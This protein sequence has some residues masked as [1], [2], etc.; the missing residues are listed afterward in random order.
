MATLFRSLVSAT[1]AVELAAAHEAD[2]RTHVLAAHPLSPADLVLHAHRC[3]P[4]SGEDLGYYTA[5]QARRMLAT[6]DSIQACVCLAPA[7]ELAA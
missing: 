7:V 3:C 2:P 5:L 4:R 1:S 6:G